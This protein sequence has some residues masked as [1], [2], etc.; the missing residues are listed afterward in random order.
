MVC[1]PGGGVVWLPVGGSCNSHCESCPPDER[2]SIT[3]EDVRAAAASRLPAVLVLTGPGEPLLRRD[4]DELVHAARRGCASN[5]ALV[6]NGRA[7]AYPRV[8]GAVASLGFSHVIVTLLHADAAE[9]DRMTRASGSHGQTVSG[10]AN[11]SRLVRD[12][13]TRVVVRTPD[14]PDLP[15]ALDSLAALARK[16]GADLLWIDAEGK[17]DL[18]PAGGL[19][20]GTGIERIL[21]EAPHEA[22]SSQGH[23]PAR[24]HADEKAVSLVVR[25]G[26]RNACSFCTTR[27]I[28]EQNRSTWHLDDL[29]VFHGSLEKGASKG[30]VS[31][32]FVAVEPLE[33]PD[34]PDLISRA[35]GLGFSRVEAWTSARALADPEVTR[36]LVSAGLTAIDVVLLGSTAAVHDEVARAPGSFDETM[37]GIGNAR[38][39]IDV[40]CH[41]VLVRQN[42]DDVG[43]IIRMAHGLDLGDPSP[44][45][46]PAPSTSAAGHYASF[47]ARMSDITRVAA[48]EEADVRR[49]MIEHGILRQIPPCILERT[50]GLHVPEPLGPTSPGGDI[51]EGKLEDPGTGI[52]LRSPCPSRDRCAAGGRCPGY[53]DLYGQVHGTDEFVPL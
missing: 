3:P 4:L 51:Q 46:V 42:M 13:M 6:T 8:A 49:I 23:A 28:Q 37:A 10:I 34:L 17:P 19:V 18:P 39:R 29:S 50:S 5:V 48:H 43:D 38:G 45:L 26:C 36:S 52:K 44:I 30:F 40:S 25:T 16:Q 35:R 12:R 53:H 20:R 21:L 2:P 11:L 7:L 27:H 31:L 24:M 1:T 32:R 9:H 47:A 33:H 15:H 22:R 14:R 41:L